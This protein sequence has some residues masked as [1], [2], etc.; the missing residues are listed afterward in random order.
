MSAASRLRQM[1]VVS[2]ILIVALLSA[3][4]TMKSVT[5]QKNYASHPSQV[6]A[7]EVDVGDRVLLRTRDGTEYDLM[8]LEVSEETIAGAVCK[9]CDPVP[10]AITDIAE[11]YVKEMSEVKTLGAGALVVSAILVAVL[12]LAGPAFPPGL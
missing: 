7:N 4:T 12:L 11:L 3:C 6:I 1:S 10:I 8:V 2:P 9:E 5:E